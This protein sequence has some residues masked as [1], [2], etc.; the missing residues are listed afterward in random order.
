MNIKL[1][2]LYIKNLNRGF[3][4][5]DF[6]FTDD[7]IIEYDKQTKK[8]NI[9]KKEKEFARLWGNRINSIDIIVGKNGAGKSTVLDLIAET[10]VNRRNLF[11]KYD[12]NNSF[13][14][15][16]FEWFAVY[17]VKENLFVVEG[18]NPNLLFEKKLTPRE[19]YSFVCK[20]NFNDK[21]FIF[22]DYIGDVKRKVPG[23][24]QK[25]S[26]NEFL[27]FL[28]GKDLRGFPWIENKF[29]FHV[30]GSMFN[31]NK[32]F[33]TQAKLTNVYRF[34]TTEY[35]MLEEEKFTAQNIVCTIEMRD[36]P[37]KNHITLP[38]YQRKQTFFALLPVKLKAGFFGIPDDRITK[39]TIK[40][41]FIINFLENFIMG[42]WINGIDTD[43]ESQDNRVIV[44]YEEILDS[45][46]SINFLDNS[47]YDDTVNYLMKVINE[48]CY[49]ISQKHLKEK[50]NYDAREIYNF[51]V[52]LSAIKEEYFVSYEKIEIPINYNWEKEIEDLL[53]EYESPYL[54]KF[55]IKSSLKD[56]FK[57]YFSNMSKGEMMFVNHFSSLYKSLDSLGESPTRNI[58]LCL[59]EPEGAFHPEWARKYIYYLVT[60]LN[61]IKKN[62]HCK[63]QVI[64]STHSPFIVSDIPRN[65]ISCIKLIE[66]DGVYMRVTQK[67]DFGFASNLY[68]IIKNDFFLESSIGEFATKEI[69]KILKRIYKLNKYNEVEIEKIKSFISIIDDMFIQNKLNSIL[70]EKEIEIMSNDEK[71]ERIKQLEEE[72][73]RLKRD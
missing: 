17:H 13:N 73:L 37:N 6:N 16:C 46:E 53:K 30:V 69:N 24:E 9:S 68:D 66:K 27:V 43:R 3:G 11:N 1:V 39:F 35:K 63:Y 36:F 32:K 57:V 5:F 25:K 67:S 8:I 60:F 54:W 4:N 65:N 47:D 22:Q 21:K 45:I 14:D 56:V 29:G 50:N 64:I 23:I 28:Y 62:K 33:I 34:L 18:A 10:D 44:S 58:I 61:K 12:E 70:K 55:D 52:V 72:L 42:A 2:Y 51:I 49:G 31:F 19:E 48:M 59:D 7:F 26:L 71:R 15:K 40:E 41:K 38:L 20:Y